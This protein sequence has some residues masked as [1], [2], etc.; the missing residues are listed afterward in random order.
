MYLTSSEPNPL[1]HPTQPLFLTIPNTYL[2]L[3]S[4]PNPNPTLSDTP[5]ALPSLPALCGVESCNDVKIIFRL[6][7]VGWVDIPNNTSLNYTL[8]DLLIAPPVD[9]SG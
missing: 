7:E 3:V 1:T 5:H 2:T 4:S 8:F 9:L 6:L